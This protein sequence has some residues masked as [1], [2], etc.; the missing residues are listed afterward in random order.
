MAAGGSG[1]VVELDVVDDDA[2]WAGLAGADVG[3]G[4]DVSSDVVVVG[5]TVVVVVVGSTV[6]VVVVGSTVVVVVVGSTVVVVVVPSV[7]SGVAADWAAGVDAPTCAPSAGR[8]DATET[9]TARRRTMTDMQAIVTTRR[10]ESNRG[11][12]SSSELEA[13]TR[14]WAETTF[15]ANV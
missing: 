5:S 12:P 3:A 10:G 15:G 13:P 4:V 7:V 8:I 1:A 14:P 6:V 9:M 11:F 2:G